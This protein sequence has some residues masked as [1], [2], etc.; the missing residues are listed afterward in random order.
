MTEAVIY[1]ELHTLSGSSFSFENLPFTP[2][3]I[4]MFIAEAY[5]G[6]KPSSTTIYTF[7]AEKETYGFQVA[8]SSSNYQQPFLGLNFTSI[9]V[10]W[11][12]DSVSVGTITSSNY[13]TLYFAGKKFRVIILP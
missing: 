8:V 9:G 1:N 2:S 10:N 6:S 7:Y 12:D 3:K 13:G 4:M 5:T 11:G